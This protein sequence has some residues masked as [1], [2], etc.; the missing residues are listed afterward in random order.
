[1]I[2]LHDFSTS[3]R[4]AFR[5]VVGSDD[6]SLGGG[7]RETILRAVDINEWERVKRWH[8]SAL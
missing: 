8:N 5:E 1:M 2:L 4:R 6:S 7:L 3:D